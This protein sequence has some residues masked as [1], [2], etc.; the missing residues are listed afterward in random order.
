M[1]KKIRSLK[2]VWKAYKL[3]VK[4]KNLRTANAIKAAEVKRLNQSCT[5]VTHIKFGKTD[6]LSEFNL[7]EEIE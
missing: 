7:V 5:R 6:E 2:R 4:A 1:A 3:S